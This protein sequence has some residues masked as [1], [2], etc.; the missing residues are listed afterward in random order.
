MCL[1]RIIVDT[2]A[3][4]LYGWRM[5]TDSHDLLRAAKDTTLSRDAELSLARSIVTAHRDA[6][7]ACLAPIPRQSRRYATLLWACKSSGIAMPGISDDAET[8]ALDLDVVVSRARRVDP[9]LHLLRAL[10]AI[11]LEDCDDAWTS[12]RSSASTVRRAEN[13]RARVLTSASVL[14]RLEDRM[15]RH[16]IGLAMQ[17]ARHRKG[18]GVPYDDLLQEGCLGVLAAVRRFDPER[19]YKFCTYAGWWVRHYVGR[20]VANHSRAIRLPVWLHA[21]I[22]QVMAADRALYDSASM[23][24]ASDEQV[25]AHLDVPLAEVLVVRRALRFDAGVSLDAPLRNKAGEF[26]RGLIETVTD[27]H[28]PTPDVALD[29]ARR[30]QSIARRVDALPARDA[31]IVREY[32]GLGQDDSGEDA[33]ADAADDQENRG[34]TL[35]EVADSLH[36]SRE[37]VR[38][39]R[40]AAL[41]RLR[42]AM[43]EFL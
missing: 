32:F 20:C 11:V 37:R 34:R 6:W 39:L 10:Q 16:N 5:S 3:R 13:H 31:R 33:A 1:T 41:D 42:P 30:S 21:R 27:P 14:G 36:I 18:S 7:H 24:P 8:H 19:G 2:L 38:Q 23:T 35:S 22:M 4:R 25:A 28:V 12:P 17:A 15:V 40:D 29:V 43:R 26:A 9:D